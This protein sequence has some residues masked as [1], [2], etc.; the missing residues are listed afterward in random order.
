MISIRPGRTAIVAIACLP[1]FAR[2]QT[3]TNG[4]GAAATSSYAALQKSNGSFGLATGGQP[5][6]L[7]VSAEDFPGV[8]RAVNDLRAD[9]ERVTGS[10][11]T[12]TTT[13][14]PSGRV[15][16]VGTLGKSPIVDRLVRDK[17]LDAR[18]LAG[19]WEA[20]VIKA[21]DNP[22]PGVSQA[23][24]VAGSDKRGTIY[25]VYDLSQEIG[26]S[27]WYWWADVS[28]PRRAGLYVN[29]GVPYDGETD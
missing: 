14:A 29:A 1:S 3:S 18:A 24:I 20:F 23:L 16:I 7:Y 26:V 21:V 6:P 11:P 2:T 15:V 17:K 12:V 19:K 8:V 5:A 27:P 13:G 22:L 10:A 9:L 4:S 28:T 25:G